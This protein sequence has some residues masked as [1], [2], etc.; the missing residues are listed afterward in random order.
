MRLKSRARPVT[1]AGVHALG[2]IA[3]AVALAT[4][5][6]VALAALGGYALRTDAALLLA[7]DAAF[8]APVVVLAL[9]LLAALGLVRRAPRTSVLAAAGA[10][11]LLA[12]LWRG[13]AAHGPAVASAA[14]AML[15]AGL[16]VET[17]ARPPRPRRG[18]VA[19]ALAASVVAVLLAIWLPL[20]GR[21]LLAPPGERRGGPATP[22]APNVLLVVLDTLR[23]DHVG[24]YGAERPTPWLDSFAARATVFTHALSSSSWT[25]P[26]H[27]TLFT[28]L[29][30]RAHAA[31]LIDGDGGTSL[32]ALGRLEDIARARPLSRDAVTLAELAA[33]A[34][35]ETGA[36]CANTAYL[37][38]H[39]GLDQGFDTYVD[40]PGSRA[41][42]RPAGLSLAVALGER[43]LAR[44]PRPAAAEAAATGPAADAPAAG[45]PAAVPPERA[46]LP[47]VAAF[48]RR[49]LKSTERYYLLAEEV[50][51]LALRWLEPRRDRRF[52]LFLNY[53]DA[54]EPYLPIGRYARLY[55]AS[56]APQDVDL[57]SIR[58]RRRGILPAERA[59]LVDAYD[60]EIRY[61]DDQLA[62]LF[63]ALEAWGVLDRTLVVVV[64]DHGESFGEHHEMGHGNGVYETEVR[65][66]LAVRLPGQREGRRVDRL[67]HLV[68]V[69]PTVAEIAGL[70]HPAGVHGVSLLAEGDAR[71]LPL[72]TSTGRY[73]DLVRDH[74]RWYDR[75]HQAVYRD[76]WKLIARSDG[77]AELYDVRADPAETRDRA[78]GEPE[79]VAALRAELV[80]FE[81]AVQPRFDTTDPGAASP[82]ALERLKALGYVE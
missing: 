21:S 4:A 13:D 34:G 76:P 24:A 58:E 10:P 75:T 68:D 20:P 62:R 53:M 55:P 17:R 46:R 27:A 37:Y 73:H 26:A 82:E 3:L 66:P 69:L 63:A 35:L 11:L 41:A 48:G 52:F 50:N 19:A 43:R 51:A 40:T 78:P 8:L 7:V 79:T 12:P 31:D 71:P 2:P 39:Y 28:G 74:P 64:A 56:A 22:E 59:A 16:A 29:H 45:A 36:I 49:L 5:A 14:A 42:A 23:W 32:A 57:W 38:R 60:A 25:L 77:T 47:G 61:L 18:A 81:A 72:V 1:A 70:E 6:D 9:A 30:P 54:H 67:V 33:R 44:R 65:V 15:V 80:R